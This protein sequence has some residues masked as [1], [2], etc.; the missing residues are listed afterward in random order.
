V[1]KVYLA[2]EGRFELGGWAAEREY[3]EDRPGLIEALLRAIV[4]DGWTVCGGRPW[5]DIPKLRA[6][7]G[8]TAEAQNVRGAALDARDAGCDVLVFVRDRDRDDS[9]RAAIE[10]TRRELLD[11]GN[12][13]AGGIACECADAWLLAIVGER[14]SESLPSAAAKQRRVSVAA[15]T[16]AAVA[17]IE[18]HGLVSVADDATSLRQWLADVARELVPD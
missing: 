7:P 9:R 2:G 4:P 8:E 14:R 11:E 10:R 15:D 18:Q 6:R 12:R 13:I 1:I 5:K 16:D 3:Q 17:V